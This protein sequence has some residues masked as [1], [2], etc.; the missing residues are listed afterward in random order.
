[1]AQVVTP[2]STEIE[3]DE[4]GSTHSSDSHEQVGKEE[5]GGVFI[6]KV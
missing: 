3:F 4:G 2:S 6:L 5:R 1:M